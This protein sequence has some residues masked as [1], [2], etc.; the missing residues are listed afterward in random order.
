METT[1]F[2]RQLN[3][4]GYSIIVVYLKQRAS[5]NYGINQSSAGTVH[6][7]LF[8]T[9]PHLLLFFGIDRVI[10]E[11]EPT[12]WRVNFV[13]LYRKEKWLTDLFVLFI[14][15][16]QS[17]RLHRSLATIRQFYSVFTYF[18][19]VAEDSNVFTNFNY[20]F[21]VWYRCKYRW[22]ER[23]VNFHGRPPQSGAV[24]VLRFWEPGNNRARNCKAGSTFV[25][26]L[27]CY[28]DRF[29]ANR[30]W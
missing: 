20:V 16:L 9:L 18:L 22:Q 3:Q 21:L 11:R 10:R 24:D 30:S 23:V 13:G 5:I 8:L 19:D 25:T 4:V 15:S 1:G 14:W 17:H 6:S 27:L 26:A 29:L 2:H 7:P 12:L 28:P